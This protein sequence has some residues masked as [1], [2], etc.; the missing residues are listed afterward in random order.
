MDKKSILIGL[1]QAGDI[2]KVT[3][4]VIKFIDSIAKSENIEHEHVVTSSLVA[5][6]IYYIK[7]SNENKALAVGN[8]MS[9]LSSVFTITSMTSDWIESM[10]V[11]DKDIN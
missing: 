10:E 8:L 2:E 4:E 7:N 3:D 5:L 11:N 6:L 1:T 9:L